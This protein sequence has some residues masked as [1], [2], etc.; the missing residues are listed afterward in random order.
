GSATITAAFQATSGTS[1]I[2]INLGNVTALKI[3]PTGN[4]NIKANGGSANFYAYATV[5][6]ES[7]QVDVSD[8]ATWTLSN[9]TDFQLQQGDPVTVTTRPNAPGAQ[10]TLTASY[11]STNTIT[12]V[13]VTLTQIP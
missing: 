3:S 6:G 13:P 4:T 7:T 12:A 8:N 5:T 11:T 9:T 1:S 10:S 2:T